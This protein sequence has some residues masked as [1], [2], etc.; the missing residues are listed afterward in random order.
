MPHIAKFLAVAIETPDRS[1]PLSH[2]RAEKRIHEV[3]LPLVTGGQNYEI[4]N[5]AGTVPKLQSAGYELLDLSQ[6]DQSDLLVRDQFGATRVE[7]VTA[8]ARA[9]FQWPASA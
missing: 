6:L 8:A 9:K 4:R 5:Q 2:L 3:I 1:D 7:I